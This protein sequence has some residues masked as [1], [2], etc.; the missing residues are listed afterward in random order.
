MLDPKN[1]SA[2]LLKLV[3]DRDRRAN[4]KGISLPQ[5]NALVTMLGGAAEKRISAQYACWIVPE[6]GERFGIEYKTMRALAAEGLVSLCLDGCA[7]LS[8][9]GQWYAM[10]AAADEAD[11]LIAIFGQDA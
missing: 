1:I 6:A 5:R 8:S 4:L 9:R 3:V 7:R 2:L 11:R 10:T